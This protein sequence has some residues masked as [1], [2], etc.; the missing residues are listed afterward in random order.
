MKTLPVT[1]YDI[2]FEDGPA[3][4]SKGDVGYDEDRKVYGLMSYGALSYAAY[5]VEELVTEERI[6]D[7]L[8]SGEPFAFYVSQHSRLTITARAFLETLRTFGIIGP[9]YDDA[10]AALPLAPAEVPDA[11][12]LRQSI[13]ELKR[14][15]DRARL[16]LEAALQYVERRLDKVRRDAAGSIFH[17]ARNLSSSAAD[18]AQLAEKCH[19]LSLEIRS[20]TRVLE[21]VES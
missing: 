21:S 18:A 9:Q 6:E 5:R 7:M 12:E 10:I 1:L 4:P 3:K 19:K 14:E 8:T 15:L 11:G 20:Q 17:T 13:T 2:P 16:E